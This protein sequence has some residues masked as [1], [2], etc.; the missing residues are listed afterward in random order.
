MVAFY[1]VSPP[2][3]SQLE[4]YWDQLLK[5][6]NYIDNSMELQEIFIFVI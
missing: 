3:H 4:Q 6:H 2:P 1:L 5:M